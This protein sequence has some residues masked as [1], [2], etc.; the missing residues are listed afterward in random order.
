MGQ[1]QINSHSW[2][3]EGPYTLDSGVPRVSETNA[4]VWIREHAKPGQ[5]VRITLEHLGDAPLDQFARAFYWGN[6]H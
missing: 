3:L 4:I 1:K 2:E 5:R 6:N